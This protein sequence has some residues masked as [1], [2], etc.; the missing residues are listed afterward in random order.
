[1]V[2]EMRGD[3]SAE[4]ETRLLRCIENRERANEALHAAN[5][6][7]SQ[8]NADFEAVLA[9]LKLAMGASCLR[10]V[11]EKIAAQAA[12][13]VSLDKEKTQ[14]EER[15]IAVRQEKEQVLRE[16]NELKASGIGGIELNR[17]V[18]NTLE[19][20]I[21]QAKAAL[22]VNKSAYER[23]DGVMGHSGW[24]GDFKFSTMY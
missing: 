8:K 2:A 1:M 15:L 24:Q 14:A 3:L 4:E 20:E 12:T 7:K 16:L 21:Q 19:N 5:L 13:S 17:E 6:V 22:K 9:E 10:E 23:L 18:Y 11:V